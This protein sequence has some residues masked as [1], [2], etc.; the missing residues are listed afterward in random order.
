[1]NTPGLGI[2][3]FSAKTMLKLWFWTSLWFNHLQLFTGHFPAA[4]GKGL[5]T[6]PRGLGSNLPQVGD[7]LT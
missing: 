2:P 4:R 1:M 5:L 6:P 3:L 7:F